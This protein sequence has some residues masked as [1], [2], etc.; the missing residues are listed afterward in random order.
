MLVQ[1]SPDLP[2]QRTLP[3]RV[4]LKYATTLIYV[5]ETKDGLDAKTSCLTDGPSQHD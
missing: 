2:L 4:T 5:E 3:D 1:G